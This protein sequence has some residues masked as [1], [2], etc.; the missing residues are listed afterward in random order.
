V[1][2]NRKHGR[3]LVLGNA[4][5]RDIFEV[6]AGHPVPV[7]KWWEDP[8]NEGFLANCQAITPEMFAISTM[9]GA[10]RRLTAAGTITKREAARIL[11][12]FR[13]FL[14]RDPF[15]PGFRLLL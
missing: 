4:A 6:S 9:A 7:V 10:L 11:F 15:P 14:E 8:A 12:F 5:P 1:S 3:V 13:V 2:P